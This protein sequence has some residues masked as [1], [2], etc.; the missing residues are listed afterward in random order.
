[1]V[2]QKDGAAATMSRRPSS[3]SPAAWR[4]GSRRGGGSRRWRGSTTVCRPAGIARLGRRR[5]ASRAAVGHGAAGARRRPA[6][7]GSRRPP[8][9][10]R[11]E[12]GIYDVLRGPLPRT[13]C[14]TPIAT[15]AAP[16]LDDPAR[17]RARPSPSAAT[18]APRSPAHGPTPWPRYAQLQRDAGRRRSIGC[19]AGGAPDMRPAAHAAALRRGDRRAP[20]AYVDAHGTPGRRGGARTRRRRAGHGP[21][22]GATGSSHRRLPPSLDHNDL[23][24]F[25]VLGHDDDTR[26]DRLGQVPRRRP[27]RPPPSSRP[28]GRSPTCSSATSTT[29]ASPRCATP[30]SPGSPPCRPTRTWWRRSTWPFAW[31]TS[32][33]PSTWERAVGAAPA[34]GVAIDDEWA[35]AALARP[36]SPSSVPPPS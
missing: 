9:R 16:R 26:Y 33:A 31:P 29:S 34:Q 6:R 10:P 1:M 12:V 36:C 7:C 27:P 21:P 35:R 25:N 22:A 3:R 23:H 30:T 8:P 28:C 4:P 15:D 18:P 32:L 11:Y 20:P 14:W 13:A 17:R 19:S 2:T 24:P 5:A